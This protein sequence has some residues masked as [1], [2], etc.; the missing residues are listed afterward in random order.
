MADVV[1]LL[2]AAGLSSRMRG[3]DKLLEEVRGEP[4]LRERAR[5]ALSTGCRV[6]VT[7]PP[8]RAARGAALAAL[9]HPRLTTVV[10][11][12][13]SE[14]LAAS[15]RRGAEWAL[16]LGAGGLMVVLPDM[17]DI[18]AEDMKIMLQ[19]FDPET[20]IRATSENGNAGH[21]VLLPA[22]ML[23]S[24]LTLRGDQG[25]RDL[26]RLSPVRGVPLPGTRATT[27]LD[28]PEDWSAWRATRGSKCKDGN[29]SGE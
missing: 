29:N 8:D 20:I 7:L 18:G 14:G 19:A 3:R 27:D 23:A 9:S 10:L 21:P 16:S 11:P 2:P 15:M 24:L 5:A 28:T 6:L 12:D 22:A 26:L 13:A 17:P 25:A 1:I 4:L